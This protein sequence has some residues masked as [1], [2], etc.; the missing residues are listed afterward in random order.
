MAPELISPESD[1]ENED[2]DEAER[3]HTVPS[4]T[5][6]TDVWASSMTVLKVLSSFSIARVIIHV[7]NPDLHAKAS[8]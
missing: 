3:Q 1:N 6:A 5:F 2:T 7:F 8:I 4:L